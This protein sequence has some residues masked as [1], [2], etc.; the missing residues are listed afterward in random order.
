[1][2]GPFKMASCV[3][4]VPL[5]VQSK[6]TQPQEN[7]T[8]EFFD[9]TEIL[10]R[11]LVFSSATA[12]DDNLSFFPQKGEVLHGFCNGDRL[13]RIHNSLPKGAAALTAVI[14]LMRLI[15]TRRVSQQAMAL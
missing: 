2:S 9:P 14:F 7:I 15:E 6:M 11:L 13:R 4:P 12:R 3:F 8:F 5:D 1:M 10:I